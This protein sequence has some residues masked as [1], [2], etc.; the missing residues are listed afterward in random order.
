[1][2]KQAPQ[3]N[4]ILSN[5][6]DYLIEEV[7]AEEEELLGSGSGMDPEESAKE[8]NPA[9]ITV[10]RDDKLAKVLDRLLLYLRIVHSVDYYNTCE[11][12]S[13]DEMPNRCGMIHVRGPIPPNRITHGEGQCRRLVLL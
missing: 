1:M 4:P 3:R 13:E 11:Y 12:P 6:T 2:M 9:E 7:S 10:E 5:I 8:G